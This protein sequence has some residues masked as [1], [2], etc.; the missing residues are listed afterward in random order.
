MMLLIVLLQTTHQT[1]IYQFHA[2]STIRDQWQDYFNNVNFNTCGGIQY[3]GKSSTSSWSDISRIFLDLESHSHIIVDAE[4][5]RIDDNYSPS[6]QFLIDEKSISHQSAISSQICGNTQLEN[7]YTISIT[8]QHNRRTVWIWANYLGGGLISLRLSIIKCQYECAGCIE[9]YRTIYLQ[10]KLHQ[11]SFNQKLITNSDGWTFLSSSNYYTYFKCGNCQFLRFKELKYSTQLPPHQDVLI[12]FFKIQGTIIIVDFLYGKYTTSSGNQQVEILIRN[13]NDPILLLNI[14]TIL[15]LQYSLIRDFEVFY[16]QAEIIFNKLNEEG[17]IQDEFLENCHPICG[18]G[19]I[20][21]QEQCDDGNLISNHSCYLCKYSCQQFCLICQFGICLQCQDG[22]II[23]ANFNCEPLCGDSNLI[24]YSTEQCELGVNGVWDDCQ[25]CRF[26]SIENCKSN[27]F[28]ICLECEIGFQIQENMCLPFCGDKLILDQ[29]EDCDDGNLQP[30]DGCFNCKFQCIEDC[31]I[32]ERG[33]CIL[34]CENGYEFVNNSC[35]SVCGDQIITKEEDCDDGNLEPYDGCFNC[36]YSCPENCFDCYQGTCLECNYQYQLLIS[37]QCKQQLNCGDGLLQEQEDCDDGNYQAADGC[38]DCFIELNWIC[39][40]M[41]RD[42]LSQCTFVKAPNLEINYLNMTQNKQY[43]SI[44]FNQKVKIYTA[45][46]LSETINFE[47]SNIDQKNWNSSLYIIQDV[48]SDVSFGEFIVQIEIQQ[49][50]EFRPVL[51]IKVNQTVANIDDAIL[52]NV[53]KSITLQYPKFLDEKQKDYSQNLKNLNKYVIYSLSGV[54]GLSLILGNGDLFV[55]IMAILQFQQYL[56]YINLQYP[57]NLEIY[58][59]FNDMITIQPLL[60]FMYFPNF[61]KFIEIQQNQEYSDGKFN[62]YKQSSNLI[63]N[64]SCQIFQLLIFLFFILLF[65]WIKKVLYKWIFCS[66]YFYYMSSL[67]LYIN[68]KVIFQFSQSFYNI[69][70]ELLKLKRFMSFQGLQKVL[71]LNGWD[72]IFK[73]LLYTRNMQNKNYLDI[74]QIIIAS[75]IL[76]LYFTIFLNFFKGKSKLSKKNTYQMFEILN[77]CRQFF[78]L[79]FLIYV[80]SSQILQLQLLLIT[81]IL[82]IGFI[83]NYRCIFNQKNYIVQMVVEISVLTFILSS[84]LYIQEFNK[85]FNE[86]KKILLGWIQAI[87]LSKGIII[88]LIWVSKNLLQ[89]LIKKNS[90]IQKIL[91][92]PLFS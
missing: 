55:E 71:F 77:L 19:I 4:F 20:Q 17:W 86:E 79:L 62:V 80:Q 70:M 40:T 45:Q 56:R 81:S 59:T 7:V 50:L 60:D 44:Q 43:I 85:Y 35:L 38:K 10:W 48:G 13:H 83:F 11:Y 41:T 82:Q 33:Q 22:F 3:F 8:L 39:I 66:R 87:I 42:S 26:I 15:I 61:F 16:T 2:N 24:P 12:R 1:L 76:I 32:C 65:Q 74:V 36:K 46:P 31:N 72:M 37:N 53:E 49:L 68:P 84:F 64:L 57:E 63:I 58:F 90:I 75:I 5:L 6:Y 14:K 23:N 89:K 69:C 52:Y 92:N 51:K 54:T 78:F 34:K 91:N 30:Y 29:Y 47:I 67:S 18:D 21:G 25:E 9:N 73:T 27:Y 88:E 28:T